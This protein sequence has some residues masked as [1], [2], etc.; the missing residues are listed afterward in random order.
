MPS[1]RA[2]PNVVLVTTDQHRA[3]LTAREGY[4]VVTTPFLDGLA[5]DGAWF[6]R[7]YA[8]SPTCVP[9]RVSLLT[10]RY[11]T[12]TRV[13]VNGDQHAATYERDLVG[14]LANAGYETALVGKNHSHLDP[15]R[16]DHHVGFGH[17]GARGDAREDRT[18]RERAFDDWLRET[19]IVEGGGGLATEATP[20]PVECQIAA[21]CVS[22]ARSWLAARDGGP[23]FLWLSIPEPHNPYQAPEPYHSMF[24]PS[25]LPPL[26]AGPDALAGRRFKWRWMRELCEARWERAAPEWDHDD[27]L[28]RLRAT[29]HGM[30]R[31]VDDQ[32][33]RFVAG[34]EDEG[35]RE[36]TLLVVHGDH[37]DFGGRYG[38]MRK[39]V[40]LPEATTR[41][42]L[43]V[44]GPGID[45]TDG[46]SHAHVSLVDL[47]PSVCD[48]VGV[49]T[50]RGVQGRSLW[51]LLTGD[52]RWRAEQGTS[53]DP[54]RAEQG[55]GDGDAFRSV[56]A[57]CGDGGPHYGPGDAP[58]LAEA[59]L[60]EINEVTQSGRTCMVRRGRWKL[61]VDRD[62][63]AELYDLSVDP[64]E[65]TDLAGRSEH[66]EVRA[67]LLAELARWSLRVRDPLPGL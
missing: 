3:D 20:F 29:Y 35:L 58:P 57:E 39:G 62:D 1:S 41:V 43:V 19:A 33:R 24:P 14:V 47:L 4:P 10:G 64:A 42:P 25:D 13:W 22:A 30:L 11:P 2:R 28:A 56:Y 16:L 53:D 61:V 51:P 54:G 27:L 55:T 63:G 17:F 36:D 40:D 5:A 60:D 31:M 67:D 45:P 7:A 44:D 48:A 37:G 32:V 59:S 52:E 12:A 26:D 38:L 23:F 49:D 18:D 46:P 6:D 15:D 8:A 50:P 66:A 65:T 34:L 9:S 21:R